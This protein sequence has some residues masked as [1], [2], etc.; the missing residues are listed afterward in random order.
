MAAET[1]SNN[2]EY[3][4]DPRKLL[5]A[6]RTLFNDSELRDLCFEVSVDYDALLGSGK[7]DKSRELILYFSR[8]HRLNYLITVF[9]EFRPEVLLEDI[10][11]DEEDE[12]PTLSQI[13]V[14]P[15]PTALPQDKSNTVIAGQSFTALIRFLSKPEVRTAVVAFQTDFEAA[16]EQ[17]D[18]L[19]DYKLVHDLF[20][21]LEN[22]YFLIQN[23]QK[24]LPADDEA[25]DNIA[26]N[27]PELRLKINDLETVMQSPTFTNV[28]TR[29][30][31]QLVKARDQ[32]RVGV[33]EFNLDELRGG[34]RIIY[35]TLN[36]QPSRINAQL[37][38]TA[39]ALRLDNLE[40]AMK[41]IHAKL[42]D[43]GITIEN[44]LEEIGRG[45]GALAGLDDRLKELVREHNAWQAIDDELRRVEASIGQ[46]IEDLEDAWYDLEPM[47]SDLI[48]RNEANWA[49]ELGN[50]LTALGEAL[51]E[52]T[53]VTVRRHFRRFRS[54]SGRRFRQVDLE[55]LTLCQD[56]QRIGESLDMLLR[57]F[58]K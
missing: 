48:H 9:R 31:T 37:V 42:S 18:I 32:V 52:R 23:D 54:Q 38:A 56:L 45:E 35:R 26:I 14:P 12:D 58:D 30:M 33:E 27:E 16:S 39:G 15:A 28:E 1:P 8:R 13:T 10:A 29:W 11:I 36:R 2:G 51:A 3:D 5:K 17:I 4:I 40:T 47:T 34:I 22:R 57:Q 21:E 41:T 20:Q 7:N 24:R 19:N 44:M 49:V 25:W 43:S 53:L 50:V 46:G 6:L 55:L